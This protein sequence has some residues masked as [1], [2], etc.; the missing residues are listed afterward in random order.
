MLCI[1]FVVFV[2][3]TNTFLFKIESCKKREI[4]HI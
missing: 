1:V 2:V 4:Q 3:F